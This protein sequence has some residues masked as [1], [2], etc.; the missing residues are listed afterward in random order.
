MIQNHIFMIKKKKH[1]AIEFIHF[2]DKQSLRKFQ[3]KI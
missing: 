3:V 1:T 2:I